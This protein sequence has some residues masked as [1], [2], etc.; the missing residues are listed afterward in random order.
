MRRSRGG[1][2]VN[3]Y[4]PLGQTLG[5]VVV[6]AVQTAQAAASRWC[7]GGLATPSVA[8]PPVSGYLFSP[9]S[10]PHLGPPAE[11]RPRYPIVLYRWAQ[12]RSFR[13]RKR[14]NRAPPHRSRGAPP[15]NGS[16][17]M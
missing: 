15:L 11:V 17:A 16:K 4:E 7:T 14:P 6:A 5:P 12:N 10:T 13:T 9:S 2:G 1:G 8:S 3:R